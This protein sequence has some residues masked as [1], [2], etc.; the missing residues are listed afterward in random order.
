[1]EQREVLERLLIDSSRVIG[2]R[3]D[4]D[5][6]NKF[7]A[8]LNQLKLWNQS[9]NLTA[10]AKDEEVIVKHFVDSLA[11]LRAVSI[12]PG[13]HILDIGAG[14]GFPGIPLK[15]VRPD[16]HLALIEP[17]HKKSSFL[18]FIVGLLRLKDVAVFQGTMESFISA[19]QTSSGYD[20]LITR[21]LNP[22]V[23]FQNAHSLLKEHGKA[24]LYSSRPLD[25]T[26][27]PSDW[28]LVSDYTFELPNS[29]GLRT[30]SIFTHR[31]G[32]SSL[33]VPRGT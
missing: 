10:I 32:S 19:H 33:A 2:V 23:I 14:A 3:I 4:A 5:Q 30:I 12:E 13:S 9:F 25:R 27:L 18:H 8:Y 17:V 26:S 11:A 22:A 6:A 24:I 7:L 20:Y 15:I 16:L 21:A 28:R 31:D 29:Y 1:M